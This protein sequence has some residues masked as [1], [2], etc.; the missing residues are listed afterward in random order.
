MIIR[1]LTENTAVSDQYGAEHGLSLYVETGAHRILFDTGASALFASNAVKMNVRLAD[2]DTAVI[3]HGHHDHGGGLSEFLK[4]NTKAPVYIG[5]KAFGDYYASF[6]DGGCRYIGLDT[7]L[8]QEDRFIFVDAYLKIGASLELF[9]GVERTRL[10][11]SGNGNLMMK[12]GQTLCPDDF[13][14][15]VSLLITEGGKRVLLAGCAHCGIV[16]ILQHIKK[17]KGFFPEVVIGG[18]H[19]YNPVKKQ[20]E[21]AETV[22]EI[23]RA[24]LETGAAFYTCHC[25]G[26]DAAPI[27][28]DIMGDKLN[29]LSAGAVLKL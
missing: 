26:P 3:S 8:Q 21:N 29:C 6:A 5:A 13:L 7:A 10:N 24:L 12:Q 27:L 1:I 18:F 15:E 4:L 22:R 23:G 9:S 17:V 2:T 28:K 19:L 25:T 20:S 11:P 14:H 16:N